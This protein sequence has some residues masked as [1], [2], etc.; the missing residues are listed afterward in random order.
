MPIILQLI[1]CSL[2]GGAFSMLAAAFIDLMPEASEGGDIHTIM[3]L[4]MGGIV[5][6]FLLE[7]ILKLLYRNS[8]RGEGKAVNSMVMIGDTIHNFIDGVAIAAGFLVSP[9]SGIIVTL[10]VAAHEIPQEIGD[11]GVMIHNGMSR[12]KAILLNLASS[13]AST[14]AAVIFYIIGN[15]AD[16]NLSPITGI[17]AGFFIYIAVADIIPSI[18]K[19]TIHK[20]SVKK[21]VWLVVGLVLVSL[22]IVNLHSLAHEYGGG[23]HSHE[24]SIT[25]ECEDGHDHDHD[26]EEE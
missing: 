18:N 21:S 15:A 24:H 1:I 22:V 5:F 6:F 26:H 25:S 8:E 12:K 9:T 7:G 2:V 17:V 4:A 23:E 20:E 11:F 14:L 16:V 13:L 19:E 10:A 3:L